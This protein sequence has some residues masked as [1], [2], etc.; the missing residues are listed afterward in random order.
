MRII[1][2]VLL[3]VMTTGLIGCAQVHESAEQ[4][5]HVVGSVAAIPQ[6]LGQG[7]AQGYVHTD[8]QPNPYNR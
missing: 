7:V 2:A 3:I 8:E 5:G 6:S 4:G 1:V